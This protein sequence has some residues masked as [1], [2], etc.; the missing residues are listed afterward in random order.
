M[1]KY[2]IEDLIQ[3]QEI[4]ED[5]ASDLKKLYTTDPFHPSKLKRHYQ[6]YDRLKT[7][8]SPWAK[9][10]DIGFGYAE[11][12]LMKEWILWGGKVHGIEFS[13]K[14]VVN[15]IEFFKKEVIHGKLSE[16]QL[17][18]QLLVT[19]GNFLEIE[20][21]K[22]LFDIALLIDV[23]ASY[24]ELRLKI[25]FVQKVVSHLRT[26]G[27]V[28]ITTLSCKDDEILRSYLERRPPLYSTS[29][30]EM[31]SI[32]ENSEL[33]GCRVRRMKIDEGEETNTLL[34]WARK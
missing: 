13:S 23:L 28:L 14:S 22:E 11:G 5:Y 18:K 21:P 27:Y 6:L 32:L 2:D 30:E 29:I 17:K 8:Y 31:E 26:G 16:K 3:A 24:K 4:A 20:L 33:S 19:Y 9:M 12:K 15:T 7:L 34:A 1:D 10:L 25:L